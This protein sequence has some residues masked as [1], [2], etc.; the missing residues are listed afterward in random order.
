Y[1]LAGRDDAEIAERHRATNARR[2][3]GR[4]RENA[5]RLRFRETAGPSDPPSVTSR[6]IEVLDLASHGL[7][8][9]EIAEQLDVSVTTISAHF[10]HI[11]T[12]LGV[13]DRAAAVAAALRHGL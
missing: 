9:A 10:E 7:T 6:Q 1:R 2:G 13:S 11:F 4:A 12:R 8:S 5:R 3:A